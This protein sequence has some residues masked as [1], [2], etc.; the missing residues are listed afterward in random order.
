MVNLFFLSMKGQGCYD[1]ESD[2]Y[3]EAQSMSTSSFSEEVEF[4]RTVDPG[5][6]SFFA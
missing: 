4:S 1:D 5:G 6:I 3:R 2:F